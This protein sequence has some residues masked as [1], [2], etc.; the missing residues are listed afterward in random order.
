V[1]IV[2]Q[3]WHLMVGLGMLMLLIMLV[4]AWLLWRR[5]LAYHRWFLWIMVIAVPLPWVAIMLG[6]TTAEVGRQPWVVY[7][8]MR[9]SAG[10][11]PTVTAWQ[12]AASLALF[13]LIYALLFIAWAWVMTSFV[14]KGPERVRVVAAGAQGR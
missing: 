8:L 11:S 13:A 4:A 12:V 9:T 10:A 2:F 1:E 5:R 7:D 14:R 3:S 6:W